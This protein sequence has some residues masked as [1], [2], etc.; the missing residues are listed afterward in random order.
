MIQD[1]VAAL[2]RSVEGSC[3]SEIEYEFEGHR[4]RIVRAVGGAG[5]PAGAGTGT[6]TAVAPRTETPAT[7]SAP[8]AVR[9]NAVIVRASMHGTFYRSP[10]PGEAP[11]VDV[12]QLVEAGQQLA[13]LEAMKML[14]AVEAEEGGR[15][16]KVLADNGAAVEPGTPLFELQPAEAA[17]V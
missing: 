11:L 17:G 15:V 4:L 14:H 8:A 10:A 7:G 16:L 1:M 5:A 3:V 2:L 12:G 9:P 6:S 13:L